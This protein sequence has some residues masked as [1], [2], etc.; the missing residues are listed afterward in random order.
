M[1]YKPNEASVIESAVF[2]PDTAHF[3]GQTAVALGKVGKGKLGY[4]GDVNT[5]QGSDAVI[6]AMCKQAMN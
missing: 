3:P 2:A 5:E 4:V 6:L 1:W